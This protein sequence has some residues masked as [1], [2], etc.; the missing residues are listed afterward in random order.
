MLPF[1]PADLCELMRLDKQ[2]ALMAA[3][4]QLLPQE[5]VQGRVGPGGKGFCMWMGR[6]CGGLCVWGQR[7][8]MICKHATTSSSTFWN[9]K[10][11]SVGL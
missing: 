10:S 5:G 9:D 7:R 3:V 4:Q 1:T 2:P 11:T 8:L 6:A